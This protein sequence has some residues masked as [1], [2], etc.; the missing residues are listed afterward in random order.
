[1]RDHGDV[2]FEETL[3]AILSMIGTDVGVEV[4]TNDGHSVLH[5]HGG[6]LKRGIE[7]RKDSTPEVRNLGEFFVFEVGEHDDYFVFE[8]GLF[9]GA[10][11][12]PDFDSDPPD[13]RLAIQLGGM[14][15]ALTRRAR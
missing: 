7:R 2:T 15:V 5:L 9:A 13:S 8:E 14:T 6:E 4:M 12:A 1:M 11:W 10:D 3:N